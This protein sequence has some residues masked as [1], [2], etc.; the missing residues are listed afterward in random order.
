MTPLFAR[1]SGVRKVPMAVRPTKFDTDA[2]TYIL[3]MQDGQ[4]VTSARLIPTSEPHLV[5]EVFPD[6]CEFTCVPR[7]P[8]FAEWTRT[9]VFGDA[10][11]RGIRGTITQLS[12]AVGRVIPSLLEPLRHEAGMCSALE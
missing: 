9:Y 4:V 2:A 1:S 10:A 5:S 7:R 3:G 12:C 11:D 6:M 8:D